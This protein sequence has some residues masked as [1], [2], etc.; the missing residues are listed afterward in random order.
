MKLLVIK[1]KA[2][3]AGLNSTQKQIVRDKLSLT[4]PKFIQVSQLGKSVFGVPKTLTFWTDHKDSIEVP[5][6]FIPSFLQFV[7]VKENNIID[8]RFEGQSLKNLK[9][10]GNLYPYQEKA[11]NS[12]MDK[13][14]G[15]IQAPTGSGKTVMIVNYLTRKLQPTLILVHTIELANQMK[16]NILKFTNKKEE[17]IGLIG[18]GIWK[19]RG[20]T[21][22]ILQT[23]AR[24]SDNKYRLLNNSFG[25]VIC[26]ECHIVPA[27]TFYSV[28]T[29][30]DAKYKFGFSATPEREDG[31][32][33]V[34]YWTTGPKIHELT[35]TDVKDKIVIP[36]IRKV[37]TDYYFPLWNSD[38]YAFMINDLIEDGNRNK[39]ILDTIEEYKNKQM[40]ILTT[41]IQHVTF[42]TEQLKKRGHTAEYLVS[43]LPNTDNPGK[44]KAMPKKNRAQVIDNLNSGKT[45]IVCSTFSLFSTGI[46]IKGLEVLFLAGPTRSEIKLKQS[47]GRIMRKSSV[48]KTP[49]IVDF[50]DNLIDLLK[51]QGYRRNQIYK[52]LNK[53]E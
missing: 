50:R 31:L 1:N 13:T 3:I 4:N 39:L 6:G 8:G 40:V 35:L 42:L 53:M 23:M 24:L 44:F 26:D 41:R 48:K 15:V 21:I 14:I 29:K 46:D 10:K 32:T 51:R 47:I 7:D 19:V 25:Q 16:E 34:I 45:K 20:I 38:E 36:T 30:L 9:F 33:D 49:E 27:A 11:V 2:T 22:C 52:Y 37:E 28:I 5:V 43:R 12:M 18:N 17:D